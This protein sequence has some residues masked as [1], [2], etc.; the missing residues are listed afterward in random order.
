MRKQKIKDEAEKA[1]KKEK[2]SI[3]EEI[4]RQRMEGDK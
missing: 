4:R 2:R 3:A 1:D